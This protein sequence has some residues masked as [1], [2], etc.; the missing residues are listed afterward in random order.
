M[1]V[2]LDQ[3][4]PDADFTVVGVAVEM[5]T[6]VPS[7]RGYKAAPTAVNAGLD[8]L[9]S[10]CFGAAV[11]R[12]L[13]NSTRYIAGTATKLYESTG[14][15]WTDVS[16]AVGGDYAAAG[17]TRWSFAQFGNV[18]LATNKADTLQYSLTGDFADVAG[19]PKA[20]LVE[21]VNQFVF[22]ADT[23]DASFGDSPNRWWCS[24]IGTYDDWTPDVDTQCVSGTLTSAPGRITAMK[25][26]G[27]GIVFYKDRAMYI[28]SYVGAPAV[29]DIQEIPGEIG[30]VSQAGIVNIGTA[31]VFVGYDNFY[32]FDGSRPVP[33]G[34]P[35]KDW[36]LSDLYVEYAY[37][38][39]TLHDRQAS[40]VYFFYPSRGSA[41]TLD[42]CLVYNYR[43]NKW[44]VDD[45]TIQEVVD[46]VSAG[47]TFDSSFAAA[48]TF[49]GMDTGITF[50]SPLLTAGSPVPAFIGTGNFTFTLTGAGGG[51][52]I[53]TNDFG[54]ENEVLLLTKS[55]PRFLT[56]PTSATMTN[57]YRMVQG[58]ALTTDVTTNYTVSNGS[59]DVLRAARWHR[60]QFVGLGGGEF[61][62]I[63][64]TTEVVGSE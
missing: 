15:T 14:T 59:F 43:V 54:S 28:A 39:K 60:L 53:T 13:D 8:A 2:K 19:A 24:A 32:M 35:L 57:Y 31:H 48:N 37:R 58:Q 27:D 64:V 7:L 61:G 52:S 12:K 4:A 34:N 11:M 44:G 33:I 3:F 30:C 25:R 23:D 56:A 16:R 20:K 51:W 38:I 21:T 49:G 18:S 26:L 29:W 40:N 42:K 55:R 50:D 10:E 63:D 5:S 6:L 17:D 45:R 62:A 41:G 47:L 46:Y 9:A 1:L 22:L 36:W